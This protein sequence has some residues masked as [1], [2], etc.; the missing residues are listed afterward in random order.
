MKKFLAYLRTSTDKKSQSGPDQQGY[1]FDAQMHAIAKYVEAVGGEIVGTYSEQMSGANNERPEM[2]KCFAH[3]KAVGASVCISKL[4]RISR[5]AAFIIALSKNSHGVEFKIAENPSADFLQIA[6]LAVIADNERQAIA[7]RVRQSMAAAK[8]AGVKFGNPNPDIA[9]M[10]RGASNAA[11]AFKCQIQPIINEI[12]SIAGVN[13][14]S[15]IARV[16]NVRGIKT[17]TG[18]MWFPQSVKM[19]MAA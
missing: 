4:D 8:R 18:K 6:L 12:K 17:R 1:S 7:S 14:L 11:K 2:L 15:G 5:D 9:A 16:L 13:S 10:N 19:V 3:A